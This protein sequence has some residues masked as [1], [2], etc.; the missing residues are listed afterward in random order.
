MPYTPRE[1]REVRC[2]LEYGVETFAGKWKPKIICTLNY[3]SPMRYSE[4]KADLANMTDTALASALRELVSDG[5][6]VRTQYD[7]VPLRVEYSLSDKG[8]SIIP[9]MQEI[10]EWTSMYHHMDEDRML[11]QC[12]TC[13]LIKRPPASD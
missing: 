6:V 4:I 10:C 7:G 12:R 3:R 9:I 11:A 5:M 13:E 8:R 1:D 2:P